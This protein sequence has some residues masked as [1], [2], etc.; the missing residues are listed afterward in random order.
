MAAGTTFTGFNGTFTYNSVPITKIKSITP[1]NQSVT[2]TEA[3]P[4]G[5]SDTQ[6]VGGIKDGGEVKVDVF[7]DTLD[8]SHAGLT[9]L[10]GTNP[11]TPKA[12]VLTFKTGNTY[13]YDSM[14]SALDF[15]E[16]NNNDPVVA[17]FT[18][19]ISGDVAITTP[20]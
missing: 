17:T 16:L 11:Q 14:I 1:N 8:T 2:M 7:Y 19:R 4:L 6:Y 5:V 20:A 13:G 10:F 9:T 18:F 12:S 15:S 3:T